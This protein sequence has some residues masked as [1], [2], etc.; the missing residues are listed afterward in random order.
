MSKASDDIQERE[1]HQLQLMQ[2]NA[3]ESCMTSFR[4]LH[5]FLQVLS[6]DE[7]KS[8]RIDKDEFQEDK[9][10]AAFWVLNNQSSEI[11]QLASTSWDYDSE[12]TEKL[13]AEYT[14]IQVKQFRETLLLHIANVKKYVAK[15][16]HHKRQYDRRMKERQMQSRESKVVSSKALDASLV[17]TECS[18][19]K[20]DEH[21]TSISSGTYITHVVDADIRLV[22]DQVPSAEVHLTTQHNV[23]ANVQWYTNQSEP[24][25]DTY[26]LEKV[27]S[28]TIPDSTNSVSYGRRL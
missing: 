26:L 27:D 15:I 12:M 9:S 10:M 25:Y 11:H 24:S 18:A 3:K 16:T 6:Y 19:T 20:S 13:F 7:S 8:M 4:L 28:N 17:V 5:S 14:G 2:E 23:L 22:N 1:L 21:I